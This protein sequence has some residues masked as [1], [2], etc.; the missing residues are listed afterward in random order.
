[1]EL[2]NILGK[3]RPKKK[4]P[5]QNNYIFLECI[6]TLEDT[7][8]EWIEAEPLENGFKI[9][10]TRQKNSSNKEP[11]TLRKVM[12]FIPKEIYHAT[13]IITNR[14]YYVLKNDG[15]IVA[16]DER[17]EGIID[18]LKNTPPWVTPPQLNEFTQKVLKNP[19]IL[20]ETVED[21]MVGITI[22]GKF[23]DP[24]GGLDFSDYGVVGLVEAKKWID[25][26]YS[27]PNK[28]YALINVA[29]LVGKLVSPMI[30][31]KKSTYADYMVYNYGEGGEGKTGL[32]TYIMLPLLD[33][34]SSKNLM[35]DAYLVHI[36]GA[37]STAQARNLADLSKLPLI[38]DEQQKESL[39]GNA[40][41][42][43]ASVIGR[44][45]IG[46]H[47]KRFGRG[48]ETKFLSYRGIFV[49]TN[50]P[51]A[52][53]LRG[54]REDKN[55]S[56][57][58]LVRRTLPLE[59]EPI[60]PRSEYFDRIT[61]IRPIYGAIEKVLAKPEVMRKVLGTSNV[62]D[63]A[64]VVIEALQEEYGEDLHEY[65]EALDTA[66]E[67]LETKK[68]TA[69]STDHERLIRNAL[70]FAREHLR[71]TNPTRIKLLYAILQ[72]PEEAGVGFSYPRSREE[73][74]KLV[75][76]ERIKIEAMLG[77]SEEDK[78][79]KEQKE[80]KDYILNTL[81]SGE[82][83]T[84]EIVIY[85][86][87]S[88]V[89]SSPRNFLGKPKKPYS[90]GA[91]YKFTLSEFISL[92]LT[93]EAMEEQEEAETESI[94]ETSIEQEAPAENT[95]A[96]PQ[97]E[98]TQPKEIKA[99]ISNSG[100]D[101]FVKMGRILEETGPLTRQELVEKLKQAGYTDKAIE[102]AIARGLK[103]NKIVEIGDKITLFKK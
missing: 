69:T 39:V 57:M 60:Q 95:Q 7:C 27:G 91:G 80:L 63:T 87:K 93:P 31:A 90:G 96:Q 41:L 73:R 8:I 64:R 9:Y 67:L 81:L 85:A 71:E 83:P 103:D 42:I 48:L 10:L 17:L 62:I 66:K 32:F 92:F 29:L 46:T 15:K 101:C 78:G 72:F 30:R 40:Q 35:E 56:E 49:G 14:K 18:Y 24:Y 38:L 53:F 98:S 75:E 99:R 54:V 44:H 55:I 37:T 79:N 34:D 12:A 89:K 97:Q 11:V 59:W 52:D 88:L 25:R 77:D 50:T 82:K 70:E 51:F 4:A 94:E 23:F 19:K 1:M 43:T 74:E 45:I 3:Y 84:P 28:V 21:L 16:I 20:K 5:G 61:G 76:Q 2:K 22:D 26:I 86:G 68:K 36:T 13:N 102:E 6:E 47:A 65:L 100:V 33:L 58:A